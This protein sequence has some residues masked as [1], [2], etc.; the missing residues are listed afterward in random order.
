MPAPALHSG[1]KKILLVNPRGF[2][3]GVKRALAII[4]HA[5]NSDPNQL[6]CYKEIVHN[7]QVVEELT[8]RGVSFIGKLEQA[9]PGTRIVF[10]AH[11]V[12]PNVRKNAGKRNLQVIDATCPFVAKVH[13]EVKKFAAQD[14]D[15]LMIGHAEHDEVVGIVG[16]A[17]TRVK[18]VENLADAADIRI[19][20][21]SKVAVVSQTTLSVAEVANIMQV[22]KRRFPQMV[23]PGKSDICYATQNRQEAVRA[24][25]AHT[26]EI[27]VLG[28]VNSSNTNRLVEVAAAAGAKATLVSSI[29]DLAKT[30]LNQAE[31]IG[32]TAGASTPE[33]FVRKVVQWLRQRNNAELTELN[34][35]EEQTIFKIQAQT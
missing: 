3:A 1:M 21:D 18:V 13:Q 15:V 31:C 5:L 17:P 30:S 9:P 20:D 16:E 25:A 26:D 24:L 10:S 28:A 8:A 14:Y 35:V 6:Y 19:R 23:K 11:G 29:D 34:V 2:C 12:A 4:E 22:L 33:S 7:R 27:L 32:I